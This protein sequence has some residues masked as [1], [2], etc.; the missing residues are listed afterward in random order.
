M[1]KFDRAGI[2]AL[3]AEFKPYDE[4]FKLAETAR[5]AL[6]VCDVLAGRVL[7]RDRLEPCPICGVTVD[8]S[9]VGLSLSVGH[10]TDCSLHAFIES[11]LVVSGAGK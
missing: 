2:D 5:I 7:H 3:I 6:P 1:S 8:E 10:A 9:S 11:G 4:L